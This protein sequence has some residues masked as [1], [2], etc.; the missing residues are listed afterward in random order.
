MALTESDETTSSAPSS[1]R[2]H[3]AAGFDVLV[4]GR[5]FSCRSRAK[6]V[7][8]GWLVCSRRR[9][10]DRIAREKLPELRHTAGSEVLLCEEHHVGLP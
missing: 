1:S 5:S 9:V 8:L 4:D 7:G 6:G 3:A 10:L 2:G